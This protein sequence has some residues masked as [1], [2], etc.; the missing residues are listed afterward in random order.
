VLWLAQAKQAANCGNGGDDGSGGAGVANGTMQAGAIAD[1]SSGVNG[2]FPPDWPDPRGFV[3]APPS[4]QRPPLIPS[5]EP[6]M[7]HARIYMGN[8]S[9]FTTALENFSYSRDDARK[10]GWQGNLQ[11]SDDF[12]RF[13]C[14]KHIAEMLTARGGAGEAR[15]VYRWDRDR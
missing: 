3:P 15:V 7:R 9:D 4:P 11:R 12:I 10:D 8:D 5:N 2:T 13:C 1:G 6:V 14:Y